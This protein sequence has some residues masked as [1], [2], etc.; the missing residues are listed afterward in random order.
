MSLQVVASRLGMQKSTLFYH[1]KGKH[2]LA[3]EAFK[4]ITEEFVELLSELDSTDEPSY[5]QL[6]VTIDRCVA[7][8]VE[9][10]ASSRLGLR[11]FVDRSSMIRNVTPD[12]RGD[13]LVRVFEIMGRWLQR[14][15]AAGVIR[16]LDARIT[17][18]HVIGTLLFYPAAAQDVGDNLLGED[19]FSEKA[20][21]MWKRELKLFLEGALGH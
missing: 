9:H 14:A 8:A 15:S 20:V 5:E 12:Q 21:R 10:P 7:Y 4:Q 6:E 18:L 3:S 11:L 1:F 17:L 16:K 2:E 19:V 13:P